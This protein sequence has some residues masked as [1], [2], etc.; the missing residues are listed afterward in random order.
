MQKSK[1]NPNRVAIA[2]LLAAVEEY[3]DVIVAT[4]DCAM[5]A[6]RGDLGHIAPDDASDLAIAIERVTPELQ[7]VAAH[8]S[9]VWGVVR[10]SRERAA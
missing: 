1:Y 3:T 6:I 2:H 7:R 5:C 8:A 9:A 10:S 4:V